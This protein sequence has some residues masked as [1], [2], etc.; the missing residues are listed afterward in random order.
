MMTNN[1][2]INNIYLYHANSP[3]QFLNVCFQ[4]FASTIQMFANTTQMFANT[5]QFFCYNQ[6]K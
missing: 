5:I 1:N 3:I 6:Q 4:M 2:N